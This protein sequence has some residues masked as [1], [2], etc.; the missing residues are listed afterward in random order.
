MNISATIEQQMTI[1]HD[2]SLRIAIMAIDNEYFNGGADAGAYLIE[3]EGDI[4][5]AINE[6]D[7]KTTSHLIVE[8][9]K[10]ILAAFNTRRNLS[11]LRGERA[12]KQRKLTLTE[13]AA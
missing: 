12:R 11:M 8:G 1:S 5:Q 7:E 9:S 13:Q 2:E 4:F 3:R 6:Y 10:E